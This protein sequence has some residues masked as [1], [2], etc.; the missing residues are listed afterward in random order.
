MELGSLIGKLGY[1]INQ[2]LR[3]YLYLLNNFAEV[4]PCIFETCYDTVNKKSSF[5]TGLFPAG[6]TCF[7]LDAYVVGLNF[8][9]V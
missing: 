8:L 4:V 5:T 2:P 6:G 7:R 1:S 3:E 9:P